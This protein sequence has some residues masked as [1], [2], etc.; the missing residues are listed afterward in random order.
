MQKKSQIILLTLLLL[1][2]FI[3]NYR[4]LDNALTGFLGTEEKGVVERVIDGDTIEIEGGESVRL[5]GINAPERGELYYSEAKE[6]LEKLILNKTVMLEF[7]GARQDKYYR[8]LAYVHYKGE[9]VNLKLVENGFANYYF[10]SGKDK[11]SEELLESWE[12]CLKRN[13]NL[14]ESSESKCALCISIEGKSVVNN[15]SFECD[16]SDWE[17]HSEGRKRFVFQGKLG[18]GEKENFDL[19]LSNSGGSLFLRDGAGKL[20][21]WNY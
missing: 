12:D 10:Y 2:I 20:V 3:I 8:T 1:V 18:S 4:F 6:F 14:C 7:V 21:V 13:V 16:V 11:Y 5:L 17:V 9:N 15:C 19:D